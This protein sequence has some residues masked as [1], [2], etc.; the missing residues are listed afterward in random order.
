VHA[1]F[2]LF[3]VVLDRTVFPILVIHRFVV[4]RFVVLHDGGGGF[5]ILF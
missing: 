4:L 3:R 5:F 2:P 1:L